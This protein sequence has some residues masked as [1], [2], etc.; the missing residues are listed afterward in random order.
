MSRQLDE[1]YCWE[2]FGHFLHVCPVFPQDPHFLA[3]FAGGGESGDGEFCLLTGL[4]DRG[5]GQVTSCVVIGQ[6]SRIFSN[7]YHCR[8]TKRPFGEMML[9][10]SAASTTTSCFRI[11]W[12]SFSESLHA[13]V[14]SIPG[15]SEDTLK[16][17]KFLMAGSLLNF[18][19]KKLIQSKIG[20]NTLPPM[21]ITSWAWFTMDDFSTTLKKRKVSMIINNCI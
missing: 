2:T 19:A 7:K 1:H 11:K 15:W 12:V 16:C 20:T 10:N 5:T 14:D 3:I 8:G 4:G 18:S 17:L 9:G 21:S 6:N 13:W